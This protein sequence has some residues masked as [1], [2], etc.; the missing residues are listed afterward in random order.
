VGVLAPREDGKP[1]LHI[2]AAL[3]RAGQT[4]TGCLRNGAT[5]WLLGPCALASKSYPILWHQIGMVL[6]CRRTIPVSQNEL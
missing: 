6:L 4:V 2:H 3:G 5:A 1:V